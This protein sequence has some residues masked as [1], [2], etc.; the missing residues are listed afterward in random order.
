MRGQVQLGAFLRSTGI[1]VCAAWQDFADSL[2]PMTLADLGVVIRA[3][4]GHVLDPGD[5]SMGAA[6]RTAA[7]HIRWFVKE[8]CRESCRDIPTEAALWELVYDPAGTINEAAITT[9]EWRTILRLVRE[10]GYSK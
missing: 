1:D 5:I 4:S 2:P 7:W 8:L 6:D 9:R 10:A 3:L